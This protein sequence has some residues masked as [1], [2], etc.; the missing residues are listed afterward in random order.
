MLTC[1]D[2]KCRIRTLYHRYRARQGRHELGRSPLLRLLRHTTTPRR[3]VRK[4]IWH[5]TLGT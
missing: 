2:W 5:G 3:R 1:K 4:E